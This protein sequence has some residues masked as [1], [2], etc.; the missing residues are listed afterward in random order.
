[1]LENNKLEKEETLKVAGGELIYHDEARAGGICP[2]CRNGII[3]LDPS[4][5]WP[6]TVG[7]CQSCH[8]GFDLG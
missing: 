3:F 5:A 8:T 2:I 7:V 1:M 4:P 6:T